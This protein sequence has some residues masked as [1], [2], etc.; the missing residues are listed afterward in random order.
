[1]PLSYFSH[2]SNLS[3]KKIVIWCDSFYY[4]LE[5]SQGIASLEKSSADDGLFW[6]EDELLPYSEDVIQDLGYL[7]NSISEWQTD[8][9]W[10]YTRAIELIDS[11]MCRYGDEDLLKGLLQEALKYHIQLDFVEEVVYGM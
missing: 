4:K 7:F 8:D 3:Q 10:A 5:Y 2:P 9:L 6:V 11:V 1:M